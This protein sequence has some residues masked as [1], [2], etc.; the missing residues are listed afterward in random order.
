MAVLVTLEVFSGRP[1]P[2]WS[3]TETQQAEF[4]RRVAGAPVVARNAPIPAKPLGYRGLRA[5]V[6][7]PG[8]ATAEIRVYKGKI[9]GRG[10][11]REDPGR[12]LEQWLLDTGR[13]S[14]S[15]SLVAHV[16]AE[17]ASAP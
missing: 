4:D 3:L 15:A 7:T 1:N 13:T 17:I 2:H 12:A 14:L 16:N 6:D 8:A 5:R 11:L 10:E 9:G